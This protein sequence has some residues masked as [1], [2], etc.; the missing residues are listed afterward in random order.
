MSNLLLCDRP[1]ILIVDDEACQR[2]AAAE[3]LQ[4]AGFKALEASSAA[5]AVLTLESV[6]KIHVLVTD[7]DLRG[8]IN[9]IVL[10][11][12]VD[13]RWPHINIIMTSG[14]VLPVPGDV[15]SRARFLPKPYA[16][17]RM[18]SAVREMI[19]QRDI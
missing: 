12:C 5:E 2:M 17:A 13:C 4:A 19:G 7:I 6:N 14:K 10:A 1:A 8:G 15:P 16:D 11:A 18:L 3:M 9:G